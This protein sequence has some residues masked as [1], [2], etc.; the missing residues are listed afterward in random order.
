MK[1]RHVCDEKHLW[2][3]DNIIRRVLQNPKK[4]LKKYI[5]QGMTVMDFGCG[6]GYMT[7]GAAK[8]VGNGKVIAVDLQQMMLDMLKDKIKG[9]KIEKRIVLHKCLEDKIEVKEKVDFALAFYVMHETPDQEKILKEIY[10]ILKPGGL[11]LVTEPSFH[12][13]EEDFQYT[14]DRAKKV[15]FEII[16]KPKMLFTRAVVLK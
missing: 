16:E 14:L 12:V 8:L 10:S 1:K 13:F 7:V 6:P 3:L 2:M 4:I 5:K 11:F 9:K 15:G